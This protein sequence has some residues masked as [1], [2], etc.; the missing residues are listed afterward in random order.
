MTLIFFK[1]KKEKKENVKVIKLF[2]GT[3]KILTYSTI[4][5]YFVN[6][7]SL[8]NTGRTYLKC[9][10]FKKVLNFIKK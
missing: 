4:P 3:V 5:M 2:L 9:S 10:K 1:K 8:I 7:F 6:F